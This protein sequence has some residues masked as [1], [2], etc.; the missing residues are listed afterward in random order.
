[1]G[2]SAAKHLKYI[3]QKGGDIIKTFTMTCGA[4]VL[5]DDEDYGRLPKNGWYLSKKEN[6]NPN[7]DYAQHDEYGKM[8]RWVLGIKPN[9]QSSVVVDHINHNGLDNRKENL[10]I[11]TTSENK[12]NIT[13]HYPNNRLH[14]TGIVLEC[15]TANRN[16][17]RARWSEGEPMRDKDG[18]RRAKQKTKSFFFDNN[19]ESCR[20]AIRQAILYRNQKCR[21]NGYILDERSTTIETA[22]LNNPECKIEELLD[23]DIQICMK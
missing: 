7:T 14:Y 21:E 11:V 23:F 8:H 4:R 12:R 5:L 16:R 22:I 9:E 3:P 20:S 6:H 18:K 15:C 10:R 1:M 17:I 13:T 2:Q 19:V